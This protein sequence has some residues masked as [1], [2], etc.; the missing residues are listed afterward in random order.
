MQMAR[1]LHESGAKVER[2]FSFYEEGHS[3]EKKLLER[4]RID[5]PDYEEM[6]SQARLLNNLL[7][8]DRGEPVLCHNDFFS[9][10]FLVKDDQISL[11]DWEYA[12][13]SDYA[14]DFGTF[15][16]CEQLSDAIWSGR[17]I[18]TLGELP[19]PK[20][21]GTTLARSEWPDGAGTSGL[22]SKMRKVRT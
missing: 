16:V 19:P 6:S 1:K 9:L 3:Y 20:R 17:S 8:A 18:I 10:N 21:L 13:M 5:A 11:I 22:S 12:G 14:N 15:A 2:S 7:L 4:T